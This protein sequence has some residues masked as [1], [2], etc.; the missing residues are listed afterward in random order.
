MGL[1]LKGN[2]QKII[3]KVF[4]FKGYSDNIIYKK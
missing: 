4:T 1:K 2:H 3:K